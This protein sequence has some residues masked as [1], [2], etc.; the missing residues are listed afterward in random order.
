MFT[1]VALAIKLDSPGPVVFV[2][3]RHGFNGRRFRI[4]KFR[5]M[6]VLEDDA[7]IKQ[8]QRLDKRVT[9]IGAWLRKSSIDELPQ[10]FNVLI[11]DMSLVGPR[12]HAAAHDSYYADLINEYAMRQH[13]KPGITGWAQIHGYR[14]E[15]STVEMMKARI[16]LDLWYVGN[17]SLLLDLL[18]VLRTIMEVVRSRNAY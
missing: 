17:W 7:S 9:R 18:I 13:V 8:A 16:D 1:I 6:C 3:N 11:G 5:T 2:Q 14:G 10:L 15:T 4:F 12:P